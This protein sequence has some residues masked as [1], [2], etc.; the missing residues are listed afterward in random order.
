MGNEKGTS[1]GGYRFYF[2]EHLG[3]CKNVVR[4]LGITFEEKVAWTGNAGSGETVYI[5][6]PALF[7]GDERQGGVQGHIDILGGEASQVQN[8]HLLEVIGE[9]VS[10]YRWLTSF[11]LRDF[12]RGKNPYPKTPEFKVTDDE[13]WRNYLPSIGRIPRNVSTECVKIVIAFEN[14]ARSNA[15]GRFASSR[16]AIEQFITDFENLPIDL[17]IV[18]YDHE[19][20]DSIEWNN[21]SGGVLTEAQTWFDNLTYDPAV[22]SD[23]ALTLADGV[24]MPNTGDRPV[25]RYDV[26]QMVPDNWPS[27]NINGFSFAP[28]GD[29][30]QKH[31]TGL[32]S[33]WMDFDI[34]DI[35]AGT[36]VTWSDSY[37]VEGTGSE[38]SFPEVNQVF[39]YALTPTNL[40][41]N[42]L[43]GA[44]VYTFT[45]PEGHSNG[46]VVSRAF[47]FTIPSGR[48]VLRFNV[49]VKTATWIPAGGTYKFLT[50]SQPVVTLPRDEGAN[51]NLA[52]QEA[53]TFFDESVD[54]S[55]ESTVNFDQ[56]GST[57]QDGVLAESKTNQFILIAGE[58]SSESNILSAISTISD[59]PA[60][61]ITGIYQEEINLV[62]SKDVTNLNRLDNTPMDASLFGSSDDIHVVDETS[63]DDLYDALASVYQYLTATWIDMNPIHM[64]YFLVTS[65]ETNALK[66]TDKIGASCDAA[67]QVL[68]DEDF[69][70]SFHLDGTRTIAEVKQMIER[71]IDGFFF[72]DTQTGKYECKLIRDD[73]DPETLFIFNEDNVAE[74]SDDINRE[75]DNILPNR[76]VLKY[77]SQTNKD[78]KSVTVINGDRLSSVSGEFFTENEQYIGIYDKT[79]ATKV[80]ERDLRAR[81]SIRW[82]G[83]ITVPYVPINLNVGSVVKIQNSKFKMN[84]IARILKI[85]RNVGKERNTII[86]F[87]E[88]IFSLNDV[89][90][91]IVENTLTTPS[92]SIQDLN[93]ANSIEAP[94]YLGYLELGSEEINSNLSN[95]NDLGV[96]V[97]I[98]GKPAP[99]H[100]GFSISLN[101]GSGWITQ[102]DFP[103]TPHILISN[104]LTKDP[105]DNILTTSSINSFGSVN[106]D[107][108]ILVN[109]EFMAIQSVISNGSNFDILVKRG[110]LDT[111]PT[112]HPV[113]S[114]GMGIEASARYEK[115]FR[116]AGEMISHKLR[117]RTTSGV[118]KLNE[119]PVIDLTFASRA[120]RPLPPGRLEIDSSYQEYQTIVNSSITLT[121]KHRNRLTQTTD[122]PEG[123]LD[124]NISPEAGTTYRIDLEAFDSGQ[125]SLGIFD[126]LNGITTNSQI[127]SDWSNI[128]DGTTEVKFIVTSIRDGYDS[129][130]SANITAIIANGFGSGFG[131]N[132][133]NP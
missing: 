66:N 29:A 48:V 5:N 84:I 116:V 54:N 87:I 30:T 117:S 81:S 67:A 44:A 88:D 122:S 19:V 94:Y 125:N 9:D 12:Y 47:N 8:E 121:W 53:N 106:L 14:S 6:E 34:S 25:P 4:L 77:S 37:T 119:T 107:D 56:F 76:L 132:F 78:T 127:W 28:F 13:I 58:D 59:F 36:T 110:S 80:A 86:E 22:V 21:C 97:S 74:W 101:E 131:Y 45:G 105:D 26:I 38:E 82:Q 18:A 43:S 90:S 3:I 85:K 69:G 51:W 39:A 109:D 120:I 41:N 24:L 79:L 33:Y 112:S 10:A 73:Y 103:I 96:A 35:P 55:I 1:F 133:G 40:A 128:P 102:E 27:E 98:G 63:S 20:A 11:V 70:L 65:T 124:D 23:V 46:N 50:Y 60:Q 7:G 114:F 75:L 126:S 113:N 49:K 32:G 130:T 16:A 61:T 129:F 72:L 111:V 92:V 118:Q 83:S 95:D 115:K 17:K 64:F 91:I 42:D 52:A 15:S 123:Y 68:F 108:L 57:L 62:P 99:F 89:S 104:A 93:G 71:H 31:N 100:I 2:N